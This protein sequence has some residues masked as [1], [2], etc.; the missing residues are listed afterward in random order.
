MATATVTTNE[1]TTVEK[2]RGLPWS[3][4]G[5]AAN[6]I[7]AQFTVFGSVFILFLDALG[8]SKGQIGLLL[9]FMPFAGL[10]AL[11]IAPR[12]AQ[13]GY[14]RTFITFWT[15][16]K[17]VTM[18]L[19]F[20]PWVYTAFGEETAVV[21]VGIIVA[22]FA[23]CRAIGET[24][25]YPW[26]QEYVPNHVRGKFTALDNLFTTIVGIVAVL[27]AGYVV[28]RSTG[29]NGFI[30]LIAVGVLFG[31]LCVWAYTQVPG[32]APIAKKE[33]KTQRDL[34]DALQDRS[35]R[36]YLIGIA[37]MTIATVPMT[38]FLPLFMAEEVGLSDGEVILLQNGTLVGSL[39][40]VYVWGWAADRYGSTPIMMTGILMRVFLP[41]LWLFM[42][43]ES[44][45][46]LYAAMGIAFFQGVA[47]M[48]WGIGSGRLLFVR[49]VPPEKK[50]DYMA[51]Y[52]AWIGVVGGLSQLLGGWI[53][54]YS[55]DFSVDFSVLILDPYS[56]LFLIGLV[57]PI[58]SFFFFRGVVQDSTVSM[59][60]FAG[61]LLRGNPFMA[62]ESMVRYHMAKDEETT[63]LLTERLGQTRSLL[64]V[65]E[66]LESL[67]DPRFNVRFEAI[68]AIGRMRPDEQLIAALGDVLHGN[69]PALSAMAAWALGRIHDQ[70]AQ[71]T[72]HEALDSDYR[73]IRGQSARSLATLGD[74]T[75]VP[76]LLSRLQKEQDYGLRV[77]YAAALGQLKAT[78]AVTALLQLLAEA[79][80]ETTQA[81]LSLAA[82]RMIG[83]EHNYIH[84][85]RQA[86]IDLG[87]AVAQALLTLAKKLP[88][89][90]LEEET[91]VLL[92]ECA[93]EWSLDAF[94]E[95]ITLLS[96]FIHSLPKEALQD[97]E[98]SVL[99]DCRVRMKQFG[100]DR[101]EYI[102]LALHVLQTAVLRNE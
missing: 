62:V 57:L 36:N 80:E 84:L 72:L 54:Q 63:V 89:T 70:R 29:L 66:L 64:A 42:P 75:A 30:F 93:V 21:F 78:E 10:I 12:V 82:A 31:F 87:T 18:F 59:G 74:D 6:T 68:V 22:G 51:L 100:R 99:E 79:T 14:K 58:I 27:A 44:A 1:P 95:G 35:F 47:N 52:Y 40:S 46:S 13:F 5:D 88:K 92:D 26:T 101:L 41:I 24:G 20:T 11:A 48:G 28:E 16:R 23:L 102:F 7:F 77:A 83:D 61:F 94:D 34:R 98:W 19:V 45:W 71:E 49:V 9:S 37:L 76:V 69:D 3:I 15:I 67:A 81:E 90:N 25:K 56:P 50:T 86:R 53:L 60:T 96:D 39:V 33:T 55:Q 2:M 91:A 85:L 8:M 4:A 38:S 43:K 65:E 73:S 32:G 17:F 97:V